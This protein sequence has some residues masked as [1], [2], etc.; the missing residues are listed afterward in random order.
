MLELA[1]VVS[2]RKSV[3]PLTW[4]RTRA[5]S[6][7]CRLLSFIWRVSMQGHAC[8]G[9][10]ESP[11]GFSFYYFVFFPGCLVASV[12][13]A[14]PRHHCEWPLT[15]CRSLGLC[16]FF[17]FFVPS[18]FSAGCISLV[19]RVRCS[20]ERTNVQTRPPMQKKKKNNNTTCMERVGITRFSCAS[21][22]NPILRKC[23]EPRRFTGQLLALVWSCV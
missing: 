19:E 4:A 20:R 5:S 15:L 22:G 1:T 12:I 23:V 21:C 10:R 6:F 11:V 3:G 9:G 7:L 14:T 17:L 18:S 16:L 2:W 8:L 13:A